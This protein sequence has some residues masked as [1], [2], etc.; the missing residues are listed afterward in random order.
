MGEVGSAGGRKAVDGNKEVKVAG[1]TT[2]LASSEKSSKIVR[3]L[4][5]VDLRLDGGY[6]ENCSKRGKQLQLQEI[7]RGRTK[8]QR[9]CFDLIQSKINADW[10]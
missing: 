4:L 2:N 8:Q 5:V 9:S 7:K 1:G 3:V 6:R 10:W